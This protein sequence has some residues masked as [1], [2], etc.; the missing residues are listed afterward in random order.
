MFLAT[1]SGIMTAVF[2]VF[3]SLNCIAAATLLIF[4]NFAVPWKETPDI[5]AA[6]E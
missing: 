3:V 2:P 5:A 6:L 1:V 4:I